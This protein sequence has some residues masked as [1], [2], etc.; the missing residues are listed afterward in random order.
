MYPP[1]G[2]FC[3]VPGSRY[4][5]PISKA[6]WKIVLCLRKSLYGQKQSSHV[7]YGTVKGFVILIGFVALRVDG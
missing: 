6:S 1:Q 5:D 2:Y 7:S 4:Y 3:L